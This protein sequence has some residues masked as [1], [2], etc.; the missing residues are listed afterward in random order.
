MK[1]FKTISLVIFVT[2]SLNAHLVLAAHKIPDGG[3]PQTQPL[4]SV[5]AGIQPDRQNSIDASGP[6]AG[7]AIIQNDSSSSIQK[8]PSSPVQTSAVVVPAAVEAK[9]TQ[10]YFIIIIAGLSLALLGLV[11][12]LNRRGK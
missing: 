8:G 7:S 10:T 5:P 6:S 12:Y 4:Q 3:M 9:K 1:N 11:F 2:F